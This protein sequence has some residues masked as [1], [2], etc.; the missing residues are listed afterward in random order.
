MSTEDNKALARRFIQEIWD[1]KNLAVA[2]ELM[3]ASHVRYNP[4]SPPGLPSGLEGFKLFG[5]AYFAAF[6]DLRTTIEDQVA[7]GEMVVTRW[8]SHGTN[9]GSL[10]GLPATHKSATITG[11][12]IIR[13]VDGKVVQT[14]TNFDNL[15]ML[16]QLGAVPAPGQAS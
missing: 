2:D 14:W 11:I 10:F 1:Q 12:T 7:E 5:S 16:Q 15:G 4:G 13:I 9:T 3:A 8:T 6:P